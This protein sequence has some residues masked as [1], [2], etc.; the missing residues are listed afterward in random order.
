MITYGDWVADIDISELVKF[1]KSHDKMVTITGVNPPSRF[2]EVLEKDNQLISFIEKPQTSRGLINGGFIVF[3]KE[4]LNY[5]TDDRKC[6]LDY[7]PFEKLAT[8]NQI[9]VYKL[10]GSWGCVDSERDLIHLNNLWN[11]GNAFWKK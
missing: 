10:S 3:N 7:G 6:E 5:L 4:L 8:K 9:M 1:H 2:G 11:Q